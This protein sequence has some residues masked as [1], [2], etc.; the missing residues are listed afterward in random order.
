MDRMAK[1]KPYSNPVEAIA[2]KLNGE[3]PLVAMIRAELYSHCGLCTARGIL[4]NH[5]TMHANKR[6][7]LAS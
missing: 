7:L 1:T 6:K 4:Y 5:E 2:K 3:G